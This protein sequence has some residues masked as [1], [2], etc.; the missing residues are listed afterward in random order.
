MLA[1][2]MEQLVA[3]QV[4]AIKNLKIDKVTVWESGGPAANGKTSTA[5]FISGL[6]KSV[7]PMHELFDMAGLSLPE[8]LGTEK[9]IEAES[10]GGDE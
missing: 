3:I 9:G 7:P 4:E 1:D 5:N 6:M 8:F 10:K 2:K